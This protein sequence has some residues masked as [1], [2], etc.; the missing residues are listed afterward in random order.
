MSKLEEVRAILH[1]IDKCE[2]EDNGGWW[3]NSVGAEFGAD[4]LA[5]IE[6]LLEVSELSCR[7]AGDQARLI[8]AL[9]AVQAGLSGLDEI[10]NG[11]SEDDTAIRAI[12]DGLRVAMAEALAGREVGS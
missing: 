2:I 1:G 12:S 11:D 3:P 9:E 6:R 8:A 5:R 4:V 7:V 10:F